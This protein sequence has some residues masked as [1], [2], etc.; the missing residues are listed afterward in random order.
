MRV[1]SQESRVKSQ[2]RRVSR[3]AL[4]Y[5]GSRLSTL[6]PRLLRSAAHAHRAVGRDHHSYD[7]RGGRDSDH[8]AVERRPPAA[9]GH[10][11][12]STRSSPAP[13]RGR[14]RAAGRTASSSSGC[15]PTRAVYRPAARIT[16]TR[17]ASK[18]S[19]SSSR[20]R[21]PD[22]IRALRVRISR[23]P[24]SETGFAVQF[25]RRGFEEPF[26]SD[27]LPEGLDKDLPPSGL[28]AGAMSSRSPV[29]DSRSRTP[30][31]TSMPM[32]FTRTTSGEPDGE[33]WIRP[34]NPAG[35]LANFTRSRSRPAG[36]R[37][38]GT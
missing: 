10:A 2:K 5:S 28:S 24:D 30:I 17:S 29:R 38:G 9:R 3:L 19:M 31:R 22:S 37:R 26:N 15:R 11:R 25:V 4:T 36:Q 35:Q 14:S 33:L 1:K 16:T 13:R 8:G 18:C 34:V 32:A 21:F 7:D 12:R 20:R 27:G 23:H 6:D